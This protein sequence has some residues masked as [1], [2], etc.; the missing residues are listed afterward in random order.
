[1][2][3]EIKK[4]S[5]KDSWYETEI[6]NIFDVANAGGDE[7]FVK[8]DRDDAK[9]QWRCIKKDDVIIKKDNKNN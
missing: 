6:G 9:L 1:M 4:C 7:W 3:V 2:L 8:K 5:D